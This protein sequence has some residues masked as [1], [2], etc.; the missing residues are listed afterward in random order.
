MNRPQNP[1]EPPANFD[2]RPKPPTPASGPPPRQRARFRLGVGDIIGAWAVIGLLLVSV[3]V[4]TNGF[5][6]AGVWAPFLGVCLVFL[7]YAGF[8]CLLIRWGFEP[9]ARNLMVGVIIGVPLLPFVTM[10]FFWLVEAFWNPAFKALGG[11]LNLAR[12]PTWYTDLLAA[13]LVGG[14]VAAWFA[15]VGGLLFLAESLFRPR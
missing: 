13:A 11:I 10:F 14:L 7:A 1:Y 9:L 15:L 8:Q 6:V 4:G 12:E 5:N 3:L 2:P